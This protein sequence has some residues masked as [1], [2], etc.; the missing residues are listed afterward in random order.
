MTAP[1]NR[2]AAMLD[3]TRSYRY[4]LMRT[5]G[6]PSFSP[7]AKVGACVFIML[8]PSTADENLDDPTIRRCVGFAQAWGYRMLHAVNLFGLRATNPKALYAAAD[9]VGP[10]NDFWIKE[11]TERA[12]VIVAAWGVHGAF[13]RRDRQV[14]DLLREKRVFCLGKT[15]HGAP[16]HPLYIKGDTKLEEFNGNAA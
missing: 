11:V 2:R 13:N 1:T 8:N 9:P 7:S 5:W 16:R 6:K 3:P 4:D 15:K 12:G 10:R 14:M